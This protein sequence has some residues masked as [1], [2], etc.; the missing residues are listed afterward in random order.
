MAILDG[1]LD[2]RN[3]LVLLAVLGCG[4]MFY[5]GYRQHEA[6]ELAACKSRIHEW[7]K[8]LHWYSM[9]NRGKYPAELGGAAPS[10]NYSLLGCG[11]QL[12]GY[13]VSRDGE[14][15]RVWCSGHHHGAM[16]LKADMPAY[17]DLDGPIFDHES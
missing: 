6:H 9:L 17:S 7:A 5:G 14:H 4:A 13:W 15:F 1:R 11:G 3:L 16:G 10:E 2:L 12:V 8:N